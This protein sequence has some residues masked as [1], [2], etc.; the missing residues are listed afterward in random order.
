MDTKALKIGQKVKLKTTH[1]A[2]NVRFF[3]GNEYPSGTIGEIKDIKPYGI[4]VKFTDNY[5]GCFTLGNVEII[6]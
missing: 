1:K 5:V 2:G 4:Y 6:K 3:A